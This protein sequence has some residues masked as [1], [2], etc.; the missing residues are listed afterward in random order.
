MY[1]IYQYYTVFSNVSLDPLALSATKQ[2]QKAGGP[3]CMTSFYWEI[4]RFL[5]DP[6]F[7]N[8]VAELLKRWNE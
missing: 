4:V 6:E 2:N 7:E 8:E 5:E 3:F 1:V